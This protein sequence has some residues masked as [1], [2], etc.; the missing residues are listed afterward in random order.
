[1]DSV[2]LE[3]TFFSYLVARASRDV[4]VAGHQQATQDWWADR[5]GQ[6]ECYV[7]QVVIDEA[8]A[9]DPAEAHKRMTVIGDLPALQV[10]DDAKSLAGLLLSTGVIPER[11]VGDA[12]H[13]AVAVT[14]GIDFLLTWNCRHLANAQIMRR[15]AAVCARLGR[16]MPII[17]TP[18]ELM[19]E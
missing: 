18:D 10:T 8:S 16:R 19:G 9:G 6:F 12:A 4:L 5:R 11:A 3:T 15:V 1:M 2:Y 14:H 17:C 13:V 7:S